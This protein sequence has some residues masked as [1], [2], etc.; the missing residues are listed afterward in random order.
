MASPSHPQPNH[1]QLHQHLQ[2][3]LG[4]VHNSATGPSFPPSGLSHSAIPHL[5]GPTHQAHCGAPPSQQQSLNASTG[6]QG[7]GLGEHLGGI[8]GGPSPG[9]PAMN[10][11]AAAAAVGAGHHPLAGGAG[12]NFDLQVRF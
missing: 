5:Q 2:N 8:S 11:L 12:F 9:P 10:L 7:L 6:P 3:H 4:M 1:H